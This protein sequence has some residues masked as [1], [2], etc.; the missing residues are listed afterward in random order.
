MKNY[1]LSVLFAIIYASSA[2]FSFAQT[3]ENALLWEISGKGLSKPSYL[4]GTFHALCEEDLVFSEK[5][6]E[7]FAKT[8]QVCMEVDLS[9]K[10]AQL[11][12]M[13]DMFMA[14]G[15][16]LQDIMS[17]ADYEKVTAFFR[18]SLNQN[19]DAYKRM[20]PMMISSI[21]IKNLLGCK[22]QSMEEELLKMGKKQKSKSLGLETLAFQMSVFDK[23]SYEEQAKGLIETANN[24][25]ESKKEFAKMLNAYK[26][27]NLSEIYEMTLNSDDTKGI[28]ED[29]LYKRN[30]DWIPK[31]E[32]IAKEKPTFFAVGAGHLAG[33]RGVI[34]LLRKSGFT[35]KA[36]E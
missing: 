1:F 25:A 14:D 23:M 12:A 6:K 19:L 33:E 22:P 35:V 10:M 30:E 29:L 3:T 31:I 17:K 2:N 11:K 28:E 5:F 13:K 4:F 36:V 34:E 27:H 21:T 26:T 16:T 24:Y 20:K 32:N 15:K 9:D 8:K 7:K 18:D